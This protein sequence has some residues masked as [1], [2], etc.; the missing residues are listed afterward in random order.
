LLTLVLV[1]SCGS[2]CFAA[3]AET[4]F[5]ASDPNQLPGTNAASQAAEEEEEDVTIQAFE[6]ALS[7]SDLTRLAREHRRLGEFD[8]ARER[9]DQA[10]VQV[11]PLSPTHVRRR[12]VFGM[13]ARLAIDLAAAGETGS[14]DD[15]ADQLFA[16][17]EAE[18]E[19]GG[20]GLVSLAVSV[21]D[22]RP[23][24]SR[25]SYLRIAFTAAQTGTASRDRMELAF[26]VAGEAYRGKDLTLA[27][28]AIDLALSD[29]QHIGPTKLNRIALIELY[30]SRIALEQGDLEAAEN[31]AVTANR[32]YEE[33]SAN[34]AQRGASEAI[35]AEIL[36][37][38]G[39]IEKALVIARD[40]QARIA[41]EEPFDDY[42][43][44]LILA[45]LARVE[46]SAGES[47]SARA[48]FQEALA[49]PALDFSW[50][51]HLVEQLTIEL[52][53]LDAAGPN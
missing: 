31:S 44:R 20:A 34:P 1:L 42:A 8:Q 46:L 2:L 22:R 23:E 41:G 32:L 17:A 28:R 40:A 12:T 36:A 18:P 52:R 30:K 33:I 5:P 27:R 37:N 10:A 35:L 4:T 45:S 3:D 50:D 38:Q 6:P 19:L 53:E 15:L 14:A 9:L 21:A 48:H 26:R 24:A 13:R 49:I 11:Q 51:H 25:L 7:W 16:E 43:K 47:S 39:A 29:T